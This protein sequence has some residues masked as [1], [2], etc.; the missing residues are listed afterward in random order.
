MFTAKQAYT[1]LE[2]ESLWQT[3]LQCHDLLTAARISHAFVGGLAVCLH[4]SHRN[5]TNIDLLLREED[6][7]PAVHAL[8]SEIVDHRKFRMIRYVSTGEPAGIGSEVRF[9]DPSDERAISVIEGLPVLT[10]AKLIELKIACGLGKPRR[11]HKDF[12]DVVELILKNRLNSSFARFLH[13][14]V[15]A[16]YRELV[17]K[18]RE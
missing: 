15:R 16:T 7:G 5:T 1:M 13:K 3:A 10:L 18:S 17:R 12:A 11:T 8:Q 2:N 9:P 4:G 6:W 14:S